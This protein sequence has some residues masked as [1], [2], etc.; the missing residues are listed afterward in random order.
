MN[1]KRKPGWAFWTAVELLA[2]VLYGAS[3]GPAVWVCTTF[4]LLFNQD[5]SVAVFYD[6]AD[7]LHEHSE[8]YRCYIH[9]WVP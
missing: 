9:L 7:W 5:H 1:E 3:Y 2:V 4:G 6:P 8:P